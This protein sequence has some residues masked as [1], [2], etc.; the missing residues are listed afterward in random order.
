[1]D[2][3]SKQKNGGKPDKLENQY[4]D[5]TSKVRESTLRGATY[6]PKT[7]EVVDAD[8]AAAADRFYEDY[9][10]DR[11]PVYIVAATDNPGDFNDKTKKAYEGLLENGYN[12]SVGKWTDGRGTAFYDVVFFISGISE[13]ECEVTCP[14][15]TGM[16]L[17]PCVRF[18]A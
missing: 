11:M 6:R 1:M 16:S 9:S 8:D 12:V 2:R 10:V 17:Q 13:E 5:G 3:V 18:Y 14:V 15:F 7:G 4:C